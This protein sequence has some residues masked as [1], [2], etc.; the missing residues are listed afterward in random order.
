MGSSAPGGEIPGDRL[1]L[2][3]SPACC[4]A[5]GRPLRADDRRRGMVGPRRRVGIA[6]RG[7]DRPRGSNLDA[8]APGELG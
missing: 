5:P 4:V 6:H 2:V 7:K 3:L 8:A 1:R